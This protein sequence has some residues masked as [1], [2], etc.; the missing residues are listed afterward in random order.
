MQATHFTSLLYKIHFVTNIQFTKIVRNEFNDWLPVM[1]KGPLQ[2]YRDNSTEP[3]N[4]YVTSRDV[5]GQRSK[6]FKSKNPRRISMIKKQT[7]SITS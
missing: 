5:Y 3:H 7:P 4:P 1:C 2:G 6:F